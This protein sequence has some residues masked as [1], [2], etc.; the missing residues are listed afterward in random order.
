M[1]DY[2]KVSYHCGHIRYLVKAW[3]VRY[4]QTQQRCPPNV[5]ATYVIP[6]THHHACPMAQALANLKLC[7]ETRPNEKCGMSLGHLFSGS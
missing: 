5:V 3:C 7:S 2:T 1:C 6:L 4:Q